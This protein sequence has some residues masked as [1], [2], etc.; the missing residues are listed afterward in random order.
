MKEE[1]ELLAVEFGETELHKL[2]AVKDSNLAAV[3]K[4]N[5]FNLAVR[6]AE[7]LSARDVAEKNGLVENVKLIGKIFE[8]I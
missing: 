5:T 3:L 2:A 4:D 7:F 8:K 1:E 6:N